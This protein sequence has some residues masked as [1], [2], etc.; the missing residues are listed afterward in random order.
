MSLTRNKM[1]R[2]EI[3]GFCHIA[4]ICL[5]AILQFNG[6]I[7][8]VAYGAQYVDG[9]GTLALW[10][11]DEGSGSTIVDAT[12]NGADGTFVGGPN[13]PTWSTGRYGAR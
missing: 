10:H 4:I 8:S 3:T 7:S 5:F 9:P 2:T 6:G 11:M 1:Q 12:G 13:I